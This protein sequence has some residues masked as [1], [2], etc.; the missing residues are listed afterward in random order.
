MKE[1]LMALILAV[2][3][4]GFPA[5]MAIA[6]APRHRRPMIRRKGIEMMAED[7]RLVHVRETESEVEL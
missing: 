5:V 6:C 1:T 4:I 3:L 2:V 7:G